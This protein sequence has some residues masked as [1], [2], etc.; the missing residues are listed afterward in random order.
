M[1]SNIDLKRD[2]KSAV[3][4][5]GVKSSSSLWLTLWFHRLGGFIRS[6]APG[7]FA[8]RLWS[9]DLEKQ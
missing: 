7:A 2:S 9:P 6:W 5:A 3:R 1:C 8:T 4:T